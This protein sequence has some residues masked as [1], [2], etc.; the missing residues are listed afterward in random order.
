MLTYKGAG[1]VCRAASRR[2]RNA[3]RASPIRMETEA[4]LMRARMDPPFPLREE[5]EEWTLEG[6]AVA[7]DQT[8]IGNYVEVEGDPPEFAAPSSRLGARLRRGDSVHLRPALRRPP[9]GGSHRSPP[10]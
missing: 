5:R 9:Q 10:T 6:C 2:A 4:I 7:L 1:P 3:R 8:P